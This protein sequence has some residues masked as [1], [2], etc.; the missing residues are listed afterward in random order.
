[1]TRSNDNLDDDFKPPRKRL[2]AVGCLTIVILLVVLVLTVLALSV[3][4]RAGGDWIADVLRKK[5]GLDLKI[6]EARLGLPFDLILKNVQARQAEAYGGFKAVEIRMGARLN[7]VVELGVKGAELDLV[8]TA[9]GWLPAA[10]ERIA[11]L[12]DVRDTPG[13]FVDVPR[14]LRLNIR[15]S[16]ISWGTADGEITRRVKGL[17]LWAMPLES[18]GRRMW[19]YELFARDVKRAGGVEGQNVRRCWLSAADNPYVE[20][21]YRPV[22][23]GNAVSRDWWSVPAMDGQRGAI[24]DE[25]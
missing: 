23:R 5:T 6:G 1:M 18:P 3:R 19:F 21:V 10:F 25:K 12:N 17:E 13:L 14:G 2:S 24:Q 20:I 8:K 7:G 11:V 15:D 16:A 9:D 4:S 22:W